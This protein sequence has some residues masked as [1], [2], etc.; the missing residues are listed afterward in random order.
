ML[1]VV[2]LPALDPVRRRSPD[3]LPAAEGIACHDAEDEG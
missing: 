3:V 2:V 1:S